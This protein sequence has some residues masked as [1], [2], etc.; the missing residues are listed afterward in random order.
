METSNT[1]LDLSPYQIKGGLS[2]LT[3]STALMIFLSKNV[4][5]TPIKSVM[6]L[7]DVYSTHLKW[8]MLLLNK[9]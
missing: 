4:T 5:P 2:I 6:L 7:L 9:V 8:Y 1:L 3:S